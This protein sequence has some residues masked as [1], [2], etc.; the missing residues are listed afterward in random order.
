VHALRTMRAQTRPSTLILLEAVSRRHQLGHTV[1]T[2]LKSYKS[3]SLWFHPS[4]GSLW[5]RPTLET[6]LRLNHHVPFLCETTR[7][8]VNVMFYE[9]NKQDYYA[10]GCD[11]IQFQRSIR[12]F[13]KYRKDNSFQDTSPGRTGYCPILH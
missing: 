12:T 8:S 10:T 2:Q 6:A 4:W 11:D 5:H 1:Q 13:R 3:T 7:R 9:L